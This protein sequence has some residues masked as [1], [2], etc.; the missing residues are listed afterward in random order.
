MAFIST[1]ATV[2]NSYAILMALMVALTPPCVSVKLHRKWKRER[3]IGRATVELKEGGSIEEEVPVKEDSPPFKMHFQGKKKKGK[4]KG[5]GKK[6]ARLAQ[7]AG[8]APLAARKNQVPQQANQATTTD[9]TR[10]QNQSSSL[11]L[12]DDITIP[13]IE[14]EKPSVP[15]QNSPEQEANEAPASTQEDPSE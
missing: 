9:Q 7:N 1:A 14:E 15:S 5:K 6:S 2:N 13:D 8:L 4:A 12:I 3:K 10:V 11:L